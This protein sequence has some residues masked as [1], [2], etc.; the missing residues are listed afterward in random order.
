MTPFESGNNKSGNPISDHT[1]DS[2]TIESHDHWGQIE[3]AANFGLDTPMSDEL[4]CGDC[5]RKMFWD[6]ADQ[7]YHHLTEPER[8][9]FLL[10]DENTVT[11]TC[12]SCGA[13]Q[14]VQQ[15]EHRTWRPCPACG[16]D[17]EVPAGS[18]RSSTAHVQGAP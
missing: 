3:A 11:I 10:P 8:G 16:T 1:A 5:L 4:V 17:T 9:C 14:T 2:C 12:P 15:W 13:T 6:E 7:R 18:I